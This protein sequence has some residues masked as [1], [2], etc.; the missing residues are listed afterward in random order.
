MSGRQVSSSSS[1][2]LAKGARSAAGVVY[3]GLHDL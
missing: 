1:Y 2:F 3:A